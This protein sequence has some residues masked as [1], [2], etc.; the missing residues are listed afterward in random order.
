MTDGTRPRRPL[1]ASSVTTSAAIEGLEKKGLEVFRYPT[2]VGS[3]QVPHFMMFYIS[4][5]S[6]RVPAEKQAPAGTIP[7]SSSSQFRPET[8][9]GPG[10]ATA[11]GG[12]VG[13]AGGAAVANRIGTR[14]ANFAN[15]A[16]AVPNIGPGKTINEA[17]RFA[18]Q[19]AVVVG[20]IA[21]GVAGGAVGASVVAAEGGSARDEETLKT[22]IALYLNQKPRTD[23][24]ATWADTNL[25]VFGGLTATA[26]EALKGVF[27]GNG[28]GMA[29]RASAALDAIK[30]V[31]GASAVIA[32]Q[33]ADK[34]VLGELGGSPADAVSA[35]TGTAI[36][37]FKTQLFKNMNFRTFNFDYTFIPKNASEMQQVESI[38]KT[39]KT[40]MHPT[41]GEEQFFLSYPAEFQIEFHY[42]GEGANE[43]VFRTSNCALTDMK[44]EYGG[45]D[46]IT[47][48]GTNGKPAEISMSLSFIELELMTR[49]RIES[50]G[51]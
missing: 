38:I 45:N 26:A 24:K 37:P 49:E 22:V 3:E 36:N 32:F 27:T 30:N 5:R 8:R 21:G 29:G 4:E 43:N 13:A 31:A 7:V 39:F 48:K 44:V 40:Y 28:E 41:L 50:G 19:K 16:L 46:F 15:K 20:T 42:K 14:V 23:Y 10:V 12:L 33:N 1:R 17:R 51:F 18:S 9:V 11:L 35:F 47:I 2:E 25:G 6:G 34:G